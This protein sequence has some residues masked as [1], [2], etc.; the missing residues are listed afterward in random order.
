MRQKKSAFDYFIVVVTILFFT[1]SLR[2][3]VSIGSLD[4]PKEFS[5]LE[6]I[7]NKSGL[8]LPQ[9]TRENRDNL[10][11]GSLTDPESIKAAEGLV[12]YNTSIRCLEFWGG[13]TKGWISFCSSVSVL[14]SKENPY[15]ILTPEDL[16][17]V[18]E[19]PNAHYRVGKNIVLAPYL[20]PGGKGYEKWGADGWLP[21]GNAT[22][23]F[24]GSIDGDNFTI[25]GLLI[26]RVA[27]TFGSVGLFGTVD[28]GTVKNINLVIDKINGGLNTHVGGVAGRVYGYEALMSN[29]KVTG[30]A[31]TGG[32]SVGGVVGRVDGGS[33]I[34]GCFAEVDVT[35]ANGIGGV[36]GQISSDTSGGDTGSMSNCY[37]LTG[38]VIGTTGVGGVVGRVQYSGVVS[39][40]YA[41]GT[42]SRG[43]PYSNNNANYLGGIAGRIDNY[44]RIINCVALNSKVSTTRGT[45]IGRV[46]GNTV[47][48]CTLSN[49]WAQNNMTLEYYDGTSWQSL[50]QGNNA[51]GIDGATIT[52]TEFN[53]V[54]WWQNSSKWNT[55]PPNSAW[56]FNIWKWDVSISL[57]VLK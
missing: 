43:A 3:Q 22:T 54:V 32:N 23:P 29:C 27:A 49:N 10:A 51:G 50:P 6:L 37:Y 14:G 56:D 36:V 24:K 1:Q 28:E 40:C 26:H 15:L 53:S 41:T 47:P 5:I 17:A 8:R 34:T 21:L 18:R 31:I 35:G 20:A 48:S 33:K 4:N 9:L 46:V 30:G 44:G 57:P 7:S 42:V 45:N 38:N 16:D 11:L 2:A 52:S 55:T 13:K 19:K 39:N 12:I 25:S